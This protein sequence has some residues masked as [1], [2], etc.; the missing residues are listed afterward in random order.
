MSEDILDLPAPKADARLAY[1]AHKLQFG[2]L[3]LPRG[4]APYPVAVVVH[5]GYWRARYD[6]THIGHLCSALT[7]A[8]IATWSLE[9]RRLGNRGGG[10]PG[11]FLDV[12]AGAEYVRVL[13]QQYPLDLTRVLTLGHSA[14]GHLA[15]WLGGARRIVP[16]SPLYRA[17]PLNIR[18]IVSL[19]GVLDLQRAWELRLSGGVVKQLLGGVPEKHPDR[20]AVASPAALLPLGTRQILLHGTEDD[21]VPYA[22][23]SEYAAAAHAA[24]DSVELQT[25]ANCG[26]FELIDPRSRQWPQVRDAALAL[27]A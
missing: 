1:G 10:W 3:R 18:G 6:L 12:A 13:A 20:Y 2:D 27:L 16:D 25:L 15:T 21:S 4:A 19:A 23:S 26:H 7:A 8:G 14:G 24:G 17:D 11:T 5:G 22:I 9:Y